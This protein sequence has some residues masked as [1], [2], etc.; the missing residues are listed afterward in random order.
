M[1]NKLRFYND[2]LKYIYEPGDFKVYIGTSSED[3]KEAD[4]TL[5]K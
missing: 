4:F 2:D 5:L 1:S 3:V